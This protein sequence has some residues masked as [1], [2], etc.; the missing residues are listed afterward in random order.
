VCVRARVCERERERER[1]PLRYL[2][3]ITDWKGKL[4]NL[5]LYLRV[6]QT[7]LDPSI[8]PLLGTTDA[9]ST[10]SINIHRIQF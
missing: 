2:R 1:D 6:S 9:R 8:A 3:S 5:H 10:I 4:V 7:K